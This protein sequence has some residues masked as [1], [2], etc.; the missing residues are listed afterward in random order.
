[1]TKGAKIISQQFVFGQASNQRLLIVFRNKT[2]N[3]F[4]AFEAPPAVAMKITV[5]GSGVYSSTSF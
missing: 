1:M 4:V 3:Y 5:S 2:A